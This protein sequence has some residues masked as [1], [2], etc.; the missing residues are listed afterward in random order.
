MVQIFAHLSLDTRFHP[1][2]SHNDHRRIRHH[3]KYYLILNDTLCRHGIDS[4]LWRCL[5]HEED[6]Q[7]LNDFH[8]G[9]CGSHLSGMA[10]AHKILHAVYFWPSVFKDCH[11]VVK[12]FPPCQDFYLK[13]CTHPAPCTRSLPLALSLNGGSIICIV[14]LS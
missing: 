8:S 1:T 4:V 6:E 9:E 13:K 7:V 5:T 11:E 2:I 3:A 12:K 10:I 14:S